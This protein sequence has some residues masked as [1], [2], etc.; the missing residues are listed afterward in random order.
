M[1]GADTGGM[2]RGRYATAVDM[3]VHRISKLM[4]TQRVEA[5]IRAMP[6]VM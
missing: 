3:T 1:P 5:D 4:L 2:K 6:T